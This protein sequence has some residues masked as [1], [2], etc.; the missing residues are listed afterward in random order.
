MLEKYLQIFSNLKTEKNRKTWSEITS[1]QAP[2]QPFLLLS[3]MDLL[4]QGEIRKNLIEHSF[5]L[6]DTFNAYWTAIMP[7]GSKGHIAYSFYRLHVNG[8]WRLIPNEGCEEIVN[9]E[10]IFSMGRLRKICAGAELDSELYKLLSK[11]KTRKALR[12]AIVN[13]YFADTTRVR[14][15]ECGQA[16]VKAYKYSKILLGVLKDPKKIYAKTALNDK[17]VRH[18]GFRKA[19]LQLYDH[20]CAI[21]GIRMLTPEGYTVVEAAHV[22]PWRESHD[23]RPKNGIALCKLCH[24]AFDEGL[25]TV[26]THYEVLVSKSVH[27]DNNCPAILITFSNRRIIRPDKAR[28]W[29]DQ[30]N[31]RWHHNRIFLH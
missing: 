2:H 7:A 10:S 23:D 16:N 13:T 22:K 24:W 6:V 21:C 30:E 28:Y 17:R 19:I 31:L 12:A 26:S 14:I 29:P 9:S 15:L 25:M 8:I 4:A 3:V 1:H 20:T 27:S 11:T 18:L 5:E